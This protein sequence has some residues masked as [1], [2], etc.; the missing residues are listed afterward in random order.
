MPDWPNPDERR[1]DEVTGDQYFTPRF[2][3]R[4][5][6]EDNYIIHRRV[7]RAVYEEMKV[8]DILIVINSIYSHS[9]A[10]QRGC[11]K[12]SERPPLPLEREDALQIC[13]S[14]LAGL[15]S[16]LYGTI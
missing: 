11:T 8:R 16:G 14:K 4:V 3:E 2:T 7:A 15:Q 6:H 1:V 10:E 12:R 9:R 5:D 13:S